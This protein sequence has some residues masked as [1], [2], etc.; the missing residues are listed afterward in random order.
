MKGDMQPFYRALSPGSLPLYLR[1][2]AAKACGKQFAFNRK[3][4]I[5]SLE[6]QG[7]APLVSQQK[8]IIL[9]VDDEEMMEEYIQDLLR[10]RGYEHASFMD[11]VKALEF[12]SKNA[13]RVELVISDIRMPGIDG[14]ELAKRA[15]E[16][17]ADVPIILLSGYSEKLPE[18]ASLPNV[19]AVLE[20]PLLKT[21]LVQAVESVMTGCRPDG[22]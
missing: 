17:K 18:A 6:M 4:L 1:V 22:Q 9:V 14:L 21:D 15:V 12:F 2:T 10:E 13:D 5:F 11:P 20:K 3:S 16:I 8:C 19:R 7:G